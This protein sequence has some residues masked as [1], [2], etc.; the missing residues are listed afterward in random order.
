MILHIKLNKANALYKLCTHPKLQSFDI[1]RELEAQ[2]THFI[3][4]S[5]QWMETGTR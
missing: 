3:E 1:I 4:L 2:V 5:R